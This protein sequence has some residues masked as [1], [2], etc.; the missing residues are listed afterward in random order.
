[1]A[2][3]GRV[4]TLEITITYLNYLRNYRNSFRRRKHSRSTQYLVSGYPHAAPAQATGY[5]QNQPQPQARRVSAAG[6]EMPRRAPHFLPQRRFRFG[7][8]S[9]L[10][11]ELMNIIHRDPWQVVNRL[12]QDPGRL[13][14]WRLLSTPVE[15]G[16]IADWVPAV[17]IKEE[18]EASCRGRSATLVVLSSSADFISI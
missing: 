6:L 2:K 1:M 5:S 9:R 17:D 15:A 7:A 11:R 16:D 10:R 14:P 8:T 4:I 3:R 18:R 12:H 13:F